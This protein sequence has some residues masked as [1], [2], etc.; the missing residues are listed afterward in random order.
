M[1]D[2]LSPRQA[3][4]R[5]LKC[6]PVRLDERT[7]YLLATN[8]RTV[9]V[10]ANGVTIRIGKTAFNYRSEATGELQGRK[11]AAWFDIEDPEYITLTDLNFKNPV[12][13]PRATEVPA[14]RADSEI[15]A[16]A[17]RESAAHASYG[18]ALY[19]DLKKE[20]PE[21]FGGRF[22]RPNLVDQGTLELG[23]SMRAQREELQAAERREKALLR[24]GQ[25]VARDLGIT[26]TGDRARLS[27]KISGMEKLKRLGVISKES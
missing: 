5:L 19:S 22:A 21:E 25:C 6:P 15:I 23:E 8:R 10:T 11:V 13:V 1:L 20:H 17:K 9:K 3:F 26:L 14:Y 2:G 27:Q 4:V 7:R 18:R 12:T 16:Q 24:K